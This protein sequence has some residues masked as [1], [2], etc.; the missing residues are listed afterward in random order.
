MID[1]I[2]SGVNTISATFSPMTQNGR[3]TGLVGEMQ[4]ECLFF[5]TTGKDDFVSLSSESK[6]YANQD[7][8]PVIPKNGDCFTIT[9]NKYEIVATILNDN[10]PQIKPYFVFILA[11]K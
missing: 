5:S 9:S 11:K 2:N 6:L 10:N 4:I 8:F 3:E 7:I 1:V